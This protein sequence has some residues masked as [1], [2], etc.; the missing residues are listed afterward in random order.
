MDKTTKTWTKGDVIIEEIKVGDIHYEYD[1]GCCVKSEVLT[2]PEIKDDMW[3]WQSKNLTTEKVLTYKVSLDCPS[4]YSLNIYTYP[5]YVGC[6][7][8]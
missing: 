1:Y 4:H 2:K 5:A 7:F 6:K 8:I 3:V